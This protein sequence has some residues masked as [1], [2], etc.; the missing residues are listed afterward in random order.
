MTDDLPDEIVS[1]SLVS[2]S[3]KEGVEE[4][5]EEYEEA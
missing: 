2:S 5:S 1:G 4:V 3:G